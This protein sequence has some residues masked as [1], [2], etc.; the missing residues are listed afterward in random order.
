MQTTNETVENFVANKTN[1]IMIEI[2]DL[3]AHF[4]EFAR[5]GAAGDMEAAR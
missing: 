4:G 3:P 2:D 5:I 1:K